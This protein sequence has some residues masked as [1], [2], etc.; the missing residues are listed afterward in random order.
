MDPKIIYSLIECAYDETIIYSKLAVWLDGARFIE[1]YPEQTI[2]N[3]SNRNIVINY[4]FK[5]S[6][7]WI[8]RNFLIKSFNRI[9]DYEINKFFDTVICFEDKEEKEVF[10]VIQI[11]MLK[12]LYH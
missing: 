2:F 10:L 11:T 1:I 12:I 9:I 4:F 8:I 5:D 3:H 7:I 6:S